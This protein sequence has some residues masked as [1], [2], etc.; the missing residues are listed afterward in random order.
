M[1][2]NNSI[3]IHVLHMNQILRLTSTVHYRTNCKGLFK[4]KKEYVMQYTVRKHGIEVISRLAM[5]STICNST[6]IILHVIFLEGFSQ[7]VS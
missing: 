7:A 3:S 1:V 5:V 6:Q 4:F 2:I